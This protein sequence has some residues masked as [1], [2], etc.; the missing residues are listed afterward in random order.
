M[1]RERSFSR[2]GA[3]TR[4]LRRM[5]AHAPSGALALVAVAASVLAAPGLAG[6]LGGALAVVMIAIAAID[7]RYFIIPD[8][9]VLAALAL[10]L[11]NVVL[12]PSNSLLA[13][14]A[15]AGL[16][17]LVLGLA[18]WALLKG[19]AWL[20]GR[21]GMGMGDVKLAFVAGVWLD[22][23]AV[24]LAI[25]VAA[26]AALAVVAV[27]AWRGHRVS[28]TTAV[29]FGAFFAPAIWLGWLLETSVLQTLY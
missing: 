17:G 12:E 2:N 8:Q 7:A 27:R 16:R 29:P 23:L 19:Y 1:A 5:R 4:V 21:E 20:R 18:F 14:V 3:A 28:R 22:W 13:A 9:L 10:G 26:V 24:S 15:S 25:E 11:L 6:V